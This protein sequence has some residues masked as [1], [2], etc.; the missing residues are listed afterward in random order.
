MKCGHVMQLAAGLLLVAVIA[1]PTTAYDQPSVNLGFTSFLDGG[2]PAGP[3]FYF[4]QYVQYYT[5]DELVDGPPIDPELDVW[6]SLSQFI[7]QSDQ[8]VLLGGKWG[9]NV[10]VPVVGFDAAAALAD[11]GTGVGDVLV[12]PFLQWDPIMGAN[13]PKFMHRIELQLLCPTGKYDNDKGLNQ[14]SNVFSFNPYWAFTYFFT[15]KLTATARIH[16]LWNAE[17]DDWGAT[18]VDHQAGQAIHANFAAAYELMPKKLRA[19]VNGYYF[20]QVSDSQTNGVDISGREE[21][22]GIG[23]GVMYSFSKEDHL[24]F[25]AYFE[26]ATEN[27]TEGTRLNLRWVHHF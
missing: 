13:G 4:S 2:P 1:T 5:S 27:R 23:P 8:P 11:N 21:V 10:M 17:N 18:S 7:Y 24:M 26:T 3:G 20:K 22:L 25:N 12:G 14:G 15:P 16:Y 9:L 6:I 19:G